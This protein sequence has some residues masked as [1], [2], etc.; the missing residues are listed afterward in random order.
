[1]RLKGKKRAKKA[2]FRVFFV[3]A[4]VLLGAGLMVPPHRYGDGMQYI[5]TLESLYRH[6]S[7]ELRDPDS[8]DFFRF[9]PDR[10]TGEMVQV[11]AFDELDSPTSGYRQSSA[12]SWYAI[13]F[14]A[15]SLTAIPARAFLGLLGGDIRKSLQLTNAL[16]LIGALYVVAF[17]SRLDGLQKVVFMALLTVSPVLWY[18]HWTH[19]EVF[20]VS[21]IVMGLVFQ[22]AGNYRMAVLCS[23]VASLQNQTVAAFTA[24]LLAEAV[25]KSR[26]RL[27]ETVRLIPAALPSLLPAAFYMLSFGKPGLFTMADEET[28]RSV[29]SFL[30]LYFDANVGMLPY[31]PV[32]LL[33]SLGLAA[34]SVRV[35]RKATLEL[36]LVAVT[37]VIGVLCSIHDNWNS[38]S[39]GPCR[40]TLLMMPFLF[41]IIAKNA[42]T[43]VGNRTLLALLAAG[44]L[45][46]A[47]ILSMLGG[48]QPVEDYVEHSYLAK[49][50]LDNAPQLYNP[51]PEIFCQRSIHNAI[52]CH[53]PTIYGKGRM[54]CKKA[55]VNCKGMA[56]LIQQCG[57]PKDAPVC[58]RDG[59]FYVN[60]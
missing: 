35:K 10:V 58:P 21:F 22:D 34:W 23:S 41:F 7:P 18:V 8:R 20:I 17:R 13:H 53:D 39:T 46:Q 9:A 54:M 28:G 30:E 49:A 4:I 24:F 12:G 48:F 50:L 14:F 44:L 16:L 19:A 55:Y 36:K 40:Y 57:P 56:I 42:K 2:Y 32:T 37:A 6:F 59:W 43:V 38:A 27:A 26:D 60:Y 15:Y 1:M 31:I 5:L 52:G 11:N 3:I 51:S 25:W 45:F 47:G 29:L 33:M